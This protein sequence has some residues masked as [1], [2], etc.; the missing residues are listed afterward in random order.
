MTPVKAGCYNAPLAFFHWRTP[1]YAIVETGGKQYKVKP[2]QK[3]K[4]DRL[5]V[6]SGNRVEL[7]RVLFISDDG[8]ALIGHPL[9]EGARVIASCTGE[10]RGRKVIAFKYHRKNRYRRKIGHRQPFTELTIKHILKP[11]ET[12]PEAPVAPKP[13][14]ATPKEAPEAVEPA[15][16]VKAA[17]PKTRTTVRKT[18][19]KAEEAPGVEKAE[20]RPAKPKKAAPKKAAAEAPRPK[21]TRKKTSPRA[22]E[23]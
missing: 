5:E 12:E 23:K 21:T 9:V 4:V 16:E 15:P 2:G 18:A 6:T 3:V 22:E 13:E 7:D 14:A 1:I 20:K 10:V 8:K 19:P 11:G 17:G